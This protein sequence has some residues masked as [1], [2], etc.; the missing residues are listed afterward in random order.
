MLQYRNICIYKSQ[1][2]LSIVQPT[3]SK[4]SK[5]LKE[6]NPATS[7]KWTLGNLSILENRGLYAKILLKHLKKWPKDDPKVKKPLFVN[8]DIYHKGQWYHAYI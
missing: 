4:H 3:T 6:V 7:K 8:K 5:I 2:I 1:S